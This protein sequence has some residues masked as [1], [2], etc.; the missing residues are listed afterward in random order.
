MAWKTRTLKYD[1]SPERLAPVSRFIVAGGM[2]IPSLPV[3]T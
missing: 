2:I 3:A 1:K